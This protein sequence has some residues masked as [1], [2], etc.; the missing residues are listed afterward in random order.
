MEPLSVETLVPLKVPRQLDILPHS[1]KEQFLRLQDLVTGYIQSLD[2]YKEYHAQLAG[3]INQLIQ[4]LNEVTDM[5][6]EYNETAGAIDGQLA[7]IREL[8]QEFINLE[9]Y[10]YQLLA[11]NY[12]QTFLKNKFKKLVEQLDQESREISREASKDPQDLE[13]LLAKFRALRETYHLRREKL[14]R[15]DEERVTGFI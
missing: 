7:K 1:I 15:W 14:N 2:A 4:K 11:A 10:H 5:I 13:S 3:A 12:N 6:N 9:T 8:H